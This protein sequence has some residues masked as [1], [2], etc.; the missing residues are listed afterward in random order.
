[1]PVNPDA[2]TTYVSSSTP[3]KAPIRFKSNGRLT[4]EVHEKLQDTGKF[5]EEKSSSLMTEL[6]LGMVPFLIIIGVLYFLF[7]RQL[8]MAGRGAMSFGKSKARLLTRERDKV[9]FT[10]VAGCDEAKE[11]VG[12][13][14]DFLKDPKKFQRIGGQIPKGILMVGPPGTGKTLLARAVAGEAEVPFFTISGSDFVEMFV[15][16]GASRRAR[17][18]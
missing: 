9:N 6:L 15:G 11:E 8:R 17:H 12:E 10:H 3:E 16:V 18:V 4:D 1:M 5:T 2:S 14:V 7:V 13:V